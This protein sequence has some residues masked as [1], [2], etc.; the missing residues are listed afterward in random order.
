[1]KAG[2][3]VFFRS[4]RL[5]LL[6]M[7]G[8]SRLQELLS[9]QILPRRWRLSGACTR[10]GRCCRLLA[11]GVPPWL[12]RRPRLRSLVRGYFEE[13]YGF[14]Y[15]GWREDGCLVFSCSSLGA[16]NLCRIY[17]RRPRLCREYPSAWGA[18]RPDLYPEC[19]FRLEDSA[20]PADGE[21]PR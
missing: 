7:A 10:C 17:R 5:V 21:F 2:R 15:E 8:I 6:P 1:V 13:N 3:T 4:L 18:E 11:V 14:V 12:G 19:G 16:D 20:G 9:R